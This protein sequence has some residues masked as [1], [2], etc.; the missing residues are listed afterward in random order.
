M[1][2]PL[3]PALQDLK[4]E[5]KPEAQLPYLYQP[6]KYKCSIRLMRLAPSESVSAA[7]QCR[8]VHSHLGYYLDVHH[9]CI[10]YAWGP[11]TLTATLDIEGRVRMITETLAEAL[12]AF[13]KKDKP[14]I[15][16]A[17]AI[18][19]DQDNATEKGSQ[20]EMMFKIF[21]MADRV[22]VWLGPSEDQTAHVYDLLKHL[23]AV[24]AEYGIKQA[25]TTFGI[26][27]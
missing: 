27:L 2:E 21:A 5:T 24:S 13:R 20:V 12:R 23:C 19:I 18:C 6:L 7:L 16:W 14:R 11:A 15:L 26:G 3:A 17:D 1:T 22:L 9:E 4:L 8:L 10:S 25:R